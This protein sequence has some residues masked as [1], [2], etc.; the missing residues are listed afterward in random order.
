M[1]DKLEAITSSTIGLVISVLAVWLVWPA[2]GWTA[3]PAQSVGVTG[4]FWALST[5]RIYLIRKVFRKWQS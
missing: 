2:F 1:M 4:M 5:V 3:S